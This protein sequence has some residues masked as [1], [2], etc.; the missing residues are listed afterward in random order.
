M[1]IKLSCLETEENQENHFPFMQKQ[2]FLLQSG[3][4]TIPFHL[5]EL[6][7]ISITQRLHKAELPHA[8]KTT[9]SGDELDSQLPA[10][11]PTN[12]AV[13]LLVL[14]A[15][16]LWHLMLPV[17]IKTQPPFFICIA[18]SLQVSSKAIS[19]SNLNCPFQNCTGSKAERDSE[20]KREKKSKS[21]VERDGCKI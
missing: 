2:Y 10:Y 6:S 9:R 8:S 7:S 16:L 3:S 11:P 18:L 4:S 17:C 13:L 19:S 14:P 1:I 12:C 21:N 5:P 15:L 20:R